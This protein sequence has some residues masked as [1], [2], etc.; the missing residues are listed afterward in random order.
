VK[1]LQAGFPDDPVWE[2]EAVIGLGPRRKSR[3][4]FRIQAAS[5]PVAEQIAR[6]RCPL[7]LS[8]LVRRVYTGLEGLPGSA[9]GAEE[10]QAECRGDAPRVGRGVAQQ[11]PRSTREPAD[12]SGPSK[13]GG[14]CAARADSG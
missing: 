3:P 10:G 6:E 14:E 13:L 11:Q 1:F 7:I 5:K 2:I 8:M 12:G 4:L 9:G